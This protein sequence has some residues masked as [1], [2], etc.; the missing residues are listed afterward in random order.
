[1]AININIILPTEYKE[2]LTSMCLLSNTYV[3]SFVLFKEVLKANHEILLSY[4]D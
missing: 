2:I 1:M 4:E 3:D